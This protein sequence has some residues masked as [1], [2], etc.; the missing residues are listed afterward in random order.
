MRYI[1]TPAPPD[2]RWAQRH[3]SCLTKLL[4]AMAKTL[5]YNFEQLDVFEGG[6]YP[7][8]WGQTEG[9]Q[10]ALRLGLVELLSGKCPLP[11]HVTEKPLHIESSHFQTIADRVT[12]PLE[13]PQS[14]S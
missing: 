4:S 3:R 2:E 7:S 11:V 5:G 13:Q 10:L 14:K 6:Y 12:K 1:N 9:Q 8:G